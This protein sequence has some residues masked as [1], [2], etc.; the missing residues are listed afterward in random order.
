MKGH[1]PAEHKGMAQFFKFLGDDDQQA[2]WHQV[3]GY[4]PISQSAVRKLQGDGW[5]QKHP[6]YFAAFDQISSGKTTAQ[7]QG[8]RIGNYQAVR[9]AL[10]AELETVVA[11][12]KTAKQGLDDAVKKGNDLLK[13]FAALYK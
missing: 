2:W 8:I 1:K 4:L 7:S 12:S 11:G 6:N 13:E 3:T 5:F 10:E 9:D